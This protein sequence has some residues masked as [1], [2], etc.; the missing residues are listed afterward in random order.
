MAAKDKLQAIAQVVDE[1]K[2]GSEEDGEPS[3]DGENEAE[4]SASDGADDVQAVEG[5]DADQSEDGG[6]ESDADK[7]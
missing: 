3:E 5:E 4:A 6:S 2:A 7:E 1:D